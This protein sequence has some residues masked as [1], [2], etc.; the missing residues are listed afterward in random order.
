[1]LKR[2]LSVGFTLALLFS[3]LLAHNP[4]LTCIINQIINS[5]NF[6]PE[7]HLTLQTFINEQ[8]FN[9]DITITEDNLLEALNLQDNSS[10]SDIQLALTSVNLE[11]SLEDIITNC[12]LNIKNTLLRCE[13]IFGNGNC[14]KLSTLIYGKKCG[15]G[16]L[17]VGIGFCSP[18]CPMHLIPV[19]SDPFFCQKTI[20]VKRSNE[21][22]E[23][24][25]AVI[26]RFKNFRGVQYLA[27]PSGFESF[28]VD[29][30]MKKCPKGWAD[31]GKVCQKPFVKRRKFEIVVYDTSLDDYLVDSNYV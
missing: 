12:D 6:S 24:T 22:K 13:S 5:L 10:Y 29:Y 20:E 23:S 3:S 18:I 19:L 8:D 1:M 2:L 4:K 27:C 25:N 9:K 16:Y 28:G 11:D 31:F 15:N 7:N 21:F 30:C 17:P 26:K 14:I